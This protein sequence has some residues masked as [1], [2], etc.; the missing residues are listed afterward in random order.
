[1]NLIKA[2]LMKTAI[3][4]TDELLEQLIH[5]DFRTDTGMD[6]AKKAI[7]LAIKE[8]DRDTRHACAD[9]VN[10]L[11][12]RGFHAL[13]DRAAAHGACINVKAV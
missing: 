13:V 5:I 1:M 4:K 9:A 11:C 12:G 2:E 3:Q 6:K 8:Q 10:G 7:R